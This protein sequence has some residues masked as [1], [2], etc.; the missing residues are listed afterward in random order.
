[1]SRAPFVEALEAHVVLL[2]LLRVELERLISKPV[3]EADI[4]AHSVWQ[5][6][7]KER[8][9]AWLAGLG[10]DEQEFYRELTS[11]AREIHEIRKGE[12]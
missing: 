2:E 9:R 8:F 10:W 7:A 3:T 11:L 4:E 6:G 12:T 5:A 1:M